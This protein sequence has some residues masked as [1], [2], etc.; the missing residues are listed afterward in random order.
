MATK[1]ASN[2]DRFPHRPL[3]L[4]VVL[5]LLL[6]SVPGWQLLR[7]Y[8]DYYEIYRHF[9]SL[10][11]LNETQ[12]RLDD[13]MG[14]AARM[15]AA[16]GNPEWEAR[17]EHCAQQLRAA[18]AAAQA[19]AP[20]MFH[21]AP[22]RRARQINARMEA[23][24]RQALELARVGDRD[25]SMELLTSDEYERV[26]TQYANQLE[27]LAQGLRLEEEAR[28]EE[29]FS[30]A[31]LA[32]GILLVGIP[33]LLLTWLAVTRAIRRHLARREAAEAALRESE[34]IN[35]TLLASLP[36]RVFYK[37]RDLVFQG[38]NEAFAR[39][40]GR[41]PEQIIGHDD[42]DFFPPELA[43]KYRADD[44]RVMQERK[45]VTLEERNLARGV[46]RFVEVVKAPVMDER[47]EVI[48]LVGL[49]TDITEKKKAQEEIHRAQSFLNTV[50]ENLPI[51][52]FIKRAEDRRLVLWNKAGE[53]LTGKKSEE[54]LGKT[55]EELFAPEEA[56]HF[57]AVDQ[58]VLEERRLVEIPEE[59]LRVPGKG[60]RILRTQKIPIFDEWGRPCHVLGIAEDITEQKRAAEKLREFA[61]RLAEN[62]RELQEFAYAASHDLQEPLRKVRAFGDRLALKYREQLGEEG[63]DYL[64]RMLNAARRMQMLIE[65]LLVYSRISTRAKPFVTVD[66][67]G[68]VREVLSDLETR[69]EQTQGQVELEPLPTLEADPTQMRQLFQNL[70]GNALK[71]HQPGIPPVVKIS[72]RVLAAAQGGEAGFS[73]TLREGQP[74]DRLFCQIQVA[75]NGIGFDEQYL[76]RIF[77]VFQRL[78]GREAYEGSG[79]GLAICRKIAQRHGGEITAR[80]RPGQGATFL[81]H[82]PLRQ[83]GLPA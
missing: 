23:I 33:L 42:R 66:L 46:E 20:Q 15:A 69:L 72:A 22:A 43:E 25:A 32:A 2:K 61:A 59:V 7:S 81:V 12:Q 48:G 60:I 70:I 9:L 38:V 21:S 54:V 28:L 41:S 27:L 8:Q 19:Q 55:D 37:N 3:T 50:I 64:D 35:R 71:F 11:S 53:R 68:V 82:L 30:R 39:D 6:F 29:Q 57:A 13:A 78:H 49:F 44:L 26:R 34:E 4:A 77:M 73:E 83:S 63:K 51:M 74:H 45:I 52:V 18:E 62:N 58:R 65:A 5:T 14:A 75:D 76:E 17:Y 40:L 16:T 31:S 24:E 56:R 80:S 47:G 1:N 67:T 36:Q 79:V 10:H